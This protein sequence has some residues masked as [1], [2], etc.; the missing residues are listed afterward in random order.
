MD[1]SERD[2]SPEEL[3]SIYEDFRKIE[4]RE[5][6]PQREVRRYQY[7]LEEDG[8]V[9][10]YVSGITE[11]KWFYL[12]DLWVEESRRRKGLGSRLLSMIEEKAASLGMEHVYLW[13]SGKNNPLFYEKQGYTP[14]AVLEDKLEVKGCHQTGYRKDL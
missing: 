1:I 9:V 12:T 8:E 14:F 6:I 4:I 13:T 3:Q 5:G 10:G 7:V 11:H 2:I